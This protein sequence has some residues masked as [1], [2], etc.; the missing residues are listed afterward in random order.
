MLYE[1]ITN[2]GSNTTYEILM[3]LYETGKYKYKN[4]PPIIIYIKN[5]SD[6]E[7][8]NQSGKSLLYQIMAPINTT[9]QIRDSNTKND[10]KRVQELVDFLGGEFYT[11]RNNFV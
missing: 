9:M 1:V 6:T 5:G 8:I 11:F 7:D 4:N 10:L 2:T 3:E